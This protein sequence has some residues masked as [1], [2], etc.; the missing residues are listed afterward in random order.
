M[1]SLLLCPL[2]GHAT[3]LTQNTEQQRGFFLIKATILGPSQ[4][5]P[6][7][8]YMSGV[9]PA[10]TAS[11]HKTQPEHSPPTALPVVLLAPPPATR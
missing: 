1:G 7:L 5:S 3:A 11:E 9:D 8:F 4:L 2:L 6:G 10:L